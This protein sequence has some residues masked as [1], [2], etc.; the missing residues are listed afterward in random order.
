M[1]VGAV[2]ALAGAGIALWV[3][4]G[5]R[6]PAAAPLPPSVAAAPEPAGAR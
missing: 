1:W 3:R 4:H 5:D 2:L 6:R